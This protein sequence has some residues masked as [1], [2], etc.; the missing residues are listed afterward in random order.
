MQTKSQGGKPGENKKERT[1]GTWGEEERK[2][3][4]KKEQKKKGWQAEPKRGEHGE[5]KKERTD[6]MR[7]PEEKDSASG[8]PEG[9]ES[10]QSEEERWGEW[11]CVKVANPGSKKEE[12]G[13]KPRVTPTT[14][15]KKHFLWGPT[16]VTG[17]I[18][19]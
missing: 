2:E 13:I 5:R 6:C 4:K 1:A 11:H 17:S 7:T 8:R 14:R 15:K 16:R 19:G 12:C 18:Q 3:E 9:G 10:R